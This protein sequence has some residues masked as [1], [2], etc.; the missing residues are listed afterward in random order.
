[1][2]LKSGISALSHNPLTSFRD[3]VQIGHRYQ[4]L[5]TIKLRQQLGEIQASEVKEVNG[6]LG[7]QYLI[8]TA[9]SG[10]G[11]PK[12]LYA[13]NQALLLPVFGGCAALSAFTVFGKG[14]NLLWL[15]GG[16]APFL[17]TLAY[18]HSR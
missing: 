15:V 8:T 7:G 16:M 17:T 11:Q 18:S 1:M 5:T 12:K 13:Y 3:P 10:N 9:R 2:G 6:V 4:E 14:Y